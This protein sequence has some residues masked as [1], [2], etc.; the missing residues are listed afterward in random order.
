[1]A[2]VSVSDTGAEV[3]GGF[4]AGLKINVCTVR[5]HIIA[6]VMDV[7]TGDILMAVRGEGA[8]K[9]SFINI[10]AGHTKENVKVLQLGTQNVTMDS[11]YNAIA[12]AADDIAGKMEKQA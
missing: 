8:S 2:N 4:G 6:R 1:M 7:E 11:V 12:K 5:A 10:K 9:S 3:M